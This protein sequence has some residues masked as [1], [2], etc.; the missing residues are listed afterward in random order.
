[1]GKDTGGKGSGLL[2]KGFPPKKFCC[3]SLFDRGAVGRG[4]LLIFFPDP[5]MD[6]DTGGRVSVGRGVLCM[7]EFCAV[8][9]SKASTLTLD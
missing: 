3:S 6:T 4:G 1:M 5:L 8:Y 9:F 7:V 2:V